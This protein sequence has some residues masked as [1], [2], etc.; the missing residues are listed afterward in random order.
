[1]EE[2]EHP[3]YRNYGKYSDDKLA[4]SLEWKRHCE[5]TIINRDIHHQS[6]WYLDK[7]IACL[8]FLLRQRTEQRAIEDVLKDNSNEDEDEDEMMMVELDIDWEGLGNGDHNEG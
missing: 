6:A 5:R 1:M 3:M 8:E 7:E 2:L 4:E